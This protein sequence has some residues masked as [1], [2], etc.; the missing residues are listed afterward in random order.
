MQDQKSDE[1]KLL[2]KNSPLWLPPGSVRALIALIIVIGYVAVNGTVDKELIM[3]VLG[4]Y[5][6]SRLAG[7]K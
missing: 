3:L 6:G 2:D 1:K 5:F 7:G 4:F